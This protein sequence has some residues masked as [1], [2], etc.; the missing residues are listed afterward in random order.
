MATTAKPLNANVHYPYE[1]NWFV[2]FV[3][4]VRPSWWP[5]LL[6]ASDSILILVAFAL[7]YWVRYQLQ[8]FVAVDPVFQTR[9][10]TYTP[11]AI[12]LV[13]VL[14]ASFHFSGVYRQRRGRGWLEEVYAIMGATTI[15]IVALITI[16]LLFRPLLYSRLIFLYTAILIT[17]LLGLSRI[18]I[19]AARHYLRQ[20]GVGVERVVLVGA[21]DMGRM[22]MRNIVAQPN[23]GYQLIGFLDDNP[24]KGSTDI[25]RFKALGP[26]TNFSQVVQNE[27]V[28]RVIICLPWQSHRTVAR[29]LNE[30]EL[31]NVKP[32]V[33]PDL[34]QLTK[35]QM[36]VEELNGIPLIST[37]EVSIAGWNLFLKRVFDVVL[38]G[39]LS[40]IMMPVALLIALAIRLDSSGPILYAQTRV[41]KNGQR[42]R[43]YKFRSMVEDADYHRDELAAFNESSGPLFK[44]RDDPRR[45]RV[46]RFLRRFSLDE[47]PQLI[48]VLQGDMSLV[49]PRPN[50]PEEVAQYQDWHKKRL[51]VSPGITGLWQV[52]GRS[53]LTFD[54]MVLLD[55]YYAE[56]WSLAMD[57]SILLRTV[58][59]VL[60]GNGAY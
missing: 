9:F 54:E 33:V 26:I 4:R 45:T 8:W 29:L 44:M 42:F 38:A 31:V 13:A 27:H 25:G 35:N 50:L 10:A 41:G 14:F 53:D 5:Y 60:M 1:R 15:G 51:S 21:G 24:T 20:H 12:A 39:I 18:L 36:E 7:A 23:L 22:V 48:N 34:F 57:L 55:I 2:D 59:K 58:P 43:L 3:L 46:G 32:Q 49:G 30:C 37:R 52:S 16:S 19:Y 6:M 11:F 17:I 56:N 47:L 40:V 28:D